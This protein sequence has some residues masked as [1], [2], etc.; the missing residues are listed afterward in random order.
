MAV[1]LSSR[2]GR[3]VVR[4][5]GSPLF[6]KVG[7]QVVPRIDRAVHRLTGGRAL[8]SS[9]MLPSLML[10]VRG[11]K[12]GQLRR[13][14]LATLPKDGAWYV[15]GS[16]FGREQH[17]VWT[18]NLA[19]NPDAHITFGGE[20]IPVHAHRL[21]EGEKDAVWPELNAVW[22]NFAVYTTRSGRDLRVFRLDRR[23]DPT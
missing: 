8:T 1:S 7:P 9:A 15:V 22:P 14:P 18:V 21:S 23:D 17:P 13:T 2:L 4:V 11:A 12:S 5:A 20:R 19:A 6:A 3:I 16:N 10:E